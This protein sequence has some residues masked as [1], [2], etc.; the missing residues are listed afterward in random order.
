MQGSTLSIH[1]TTSRDNAEI[2]KQ[3]AL[4]QIRQIAQGK[5]TQNE[6]KAVQVPLAVNSMTLNGNSKKDKQQEQIIAL[7]ALNIYAETGE[8]PNLEK[9][10]DEYNAK[11]ITTQNVTTLAEKIINNARFRD[12]TIKSLPQHKHNWEKQ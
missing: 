9:Q 7:A 2:T 10:N 12:I 11:D 1:F 4:N 5:F 3:Q 6:F 8:I